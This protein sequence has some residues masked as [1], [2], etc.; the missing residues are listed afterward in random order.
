MTPL[1]DQQVEQHWEDELTGL[2]TGSRLDTLA[3]D[4][5]LARRTVATARAE[6]RRR[7]ARLLQDRASRRVPAAVREELLSFREQV[8]ALEDEG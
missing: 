7:V 8:L 4:H 3:R 2:K 5:L 6:E 1:T